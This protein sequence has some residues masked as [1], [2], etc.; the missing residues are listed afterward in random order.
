MKRRNL[1]TKKGK[2]QTWLITALLAAGAVA[3]VVFVFLPLQQMIETLRGQVQERRQQIMQAQSL[4]G[5]VAQARI[6]LTSAR[7]VGDQWRGDAPKQAQLITHFAHLTKQAE[8]AGVAIDRLDPLPAVELNLVAQQ[9][10]T[11]QFHAPFSAVF[12]LLHRLEA[13]PGTLWVRDLRLHAS[14][15]GSNTL[16]GELTLT[17]F[18]DRTD[19]SN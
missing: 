8:E 5:T 2:P 14:T 6:R 1:H 18:V 7:E 11:M 10:V 17:I 9:N 12:D 15:E 4:A 16:R 13:L 3:Y 19:Y